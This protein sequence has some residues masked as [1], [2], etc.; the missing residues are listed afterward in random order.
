MLA[1]LVLLK[2]SSSLT[3]FFFVNTTFSSSPIFKDPTTIHSTLGFLLS[4]FHHTFYSV[5]LLYFQTINTFHLN[6]LKYIKLENKS[7]NEKFSYLIVNFRFQ[8]ILIYIKICL[9]K[10]VA[11]AF[12]FFL[13]NF[14]I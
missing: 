14:V 8:Y 5:F 11:S 7:L 1:N 10:W 6:L 13:V 2:L 12:H 3:T 4:P 9:K